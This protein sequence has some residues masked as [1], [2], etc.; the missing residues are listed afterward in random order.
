MKFKNYYMK[1]K[2]F[3]EY[4]FIKEM[5]ETRRRCTLFISF[6]DQLANLQTKSSKTPGN[7]YICSQLKFHI[8]KAF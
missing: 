7:E 1:G 2:R 4:H 8:F 5:K 3:R 6:N